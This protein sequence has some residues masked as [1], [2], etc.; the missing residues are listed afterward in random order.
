MSFY[1]PVSGGTVEA[2]DLSGMRVA[3][4]GAGGG[5]GSATARLVASMGADVM[6]ADLEAPAPLADY[7]SSKG[8]EATATALDVTDRDAVDAWA[9]DCGAVDALIDCAAI[10]PFDDGITL[11][12]SYHPSQHNTLTGR[13]TPEMFS[14]V[15]SKAGPCP[16][17]RK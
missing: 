16:G 6:L 1:I 3:I 10:C 14:S 15:F 11:I 7:I 2:F 8:R 9:A 4:S 17:P 13:L 5:I 12:S